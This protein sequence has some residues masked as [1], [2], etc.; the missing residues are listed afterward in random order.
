MP[1]KGIFS[2]FEL[3]YIENSIPV[4]SL[5]KLVVMVKTINKENLYTPF[6]LAEKLLSWQSELN[7]MIGSMY[8]KPKTE[9]LCNCGT[10]LPI[11]RT[12]KSP[13]FSDLRSC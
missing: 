8:N 6:H 2:L 9:N 13:A 12:H 3:E 4:G 5:H 7:I 11:A 1:L 10:S